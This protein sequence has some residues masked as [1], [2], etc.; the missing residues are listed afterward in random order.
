MLASVLT[1]LLLVGV[2]GV[3]NAARVALSNARHNRLEAD[4]ARKA[5][6]AEAALR[7]AERPE[8]LVAGSR[9]MVALLVV[10][11]VLASGYSWISFLVSLLGDPTPSN[12]FISYMV[13]VGA[14]S[15]VVVVFGELMPSEL[16]MRHPEIV[17][18]LLAPV[19]LVALLAL[20]PCAAIATRVVS[21]VLGP[22]RPETVSDEDV[23]EDIRDLVDEGQKAGV[24]E[25]GEKE[26]IDRVFKLDDKPLATLMTPRADVMFLDTCADIAT[27]IRL[28]AESKHTW[29][30]VRGA[31][32]D[33]VLGIVSL[34]DL[35]LV[36]DCGE[37]YPRGIL[38]IL[39]EPLDV[40]T[41]ISALKVLERFRESGSR[42]GIVRD[43][44]GGI[45]GIVTVYDVLQVI[46]GDIGE[47]PGSEDRTVIQRED[48][49]FLVDA[50]GDVR[51][52]FETLGI[53]DESPFNGAEFHSVGG[54][55][56]TTLGYVPREG[57]RFEAF[58]YSFEVVD[59]DNKRIDKVLISPL[60]QATLEPK[61]VVGS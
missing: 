29:F 23:E 19:M 3:F 36:R 30:P 8:E 46:A 27:T 61:R 25:Q 51:E 35:V 49:S 24:I 18:R 44:Y 47:G 5:F 11:T 33:D 16:A 31:G 32:E 37:R 20:R 22:V 53:A 56:M 57:E 15:F 48:G 10:A 4:L 40:P 17:S 6:G 54:Y 38:D 14:L 21:L 60:E 7:I 9:V 41:S 59:M 50:G 28:A 2:V 12:L 55:V 26:I 1:T 43:E 34:H 52:V 45:S 13:V 39:S 42:F 58:G